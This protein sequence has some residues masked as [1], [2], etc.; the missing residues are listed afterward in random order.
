MAEAIDR[1]VRL[2]LGTLPVAGALYLA[3]LLVARAPRA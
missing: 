3:G 2:A 1:R